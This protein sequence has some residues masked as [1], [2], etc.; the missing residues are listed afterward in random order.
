MIKANPS[1]KGN[2]FAFNLF[3][4]AKGTRTPDLCVANASLY[5]LSYNPTGRVT[6]KLPRFTQPL[7]SANKLPL[8][9]NVILFG[10]GG[11]RAV[12][13]GSLGRLRDREL[14]SLAT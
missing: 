11:E 13:Y 4:G 3:G 8:P 6:I 7:P 5:Q 1:P 10:G 12:A 2:G 9:R 14:S